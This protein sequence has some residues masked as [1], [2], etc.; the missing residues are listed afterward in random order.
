MPEVSEQGHQ[1][2][3]KQQK[4]QWEIHHDGLYGLLLILELSIPKECI[5]LRELYFLNFC[6]NLPLYF[7]HSSTRVHP[8]HGGHGQLPIIRPHLRELPRGFNPFRHLRQWGRIHP[9]P[10]GEIT[11]S[12]GIRNIR[13]GRFQQHG[14]FLLVIPVHA[15]RHPILN[16]FHRLHHIR[17]RDPQGSGLHGIIHRTNHHRHTSPLVT[18]IRH[19][20]IA[21]HNIHGNTHQ[22][23]QHRRIRSQKTSFNQRL[24]Q[25]AQFET[26]HLDKRLRVFRRERI[27]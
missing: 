26:I 6:P 18:G 11:Q 20:R 1:N 16:G 9:V 2:D 15:N 14:Y 21:T 7:R 8:T 3:N 12:L 19:F 22:R 27:L 24:V 13:P 10:H 17:L 25:R 5:S 4:C 23:I